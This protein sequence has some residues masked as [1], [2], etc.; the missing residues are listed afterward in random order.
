M[1]K[2]L[3]IKGFGLRDFLITTLITLVVG[4]IGAWAADMNTR[5]AKTE[6]QV[7]EDHTKLEVIIKQGEAL[8]ERQETFDHKLDRLINMHLP[9]VPHAR[10]Q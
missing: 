3:P 1:V 6:S 10:G 7:V 2:L 5:V 4:L 8:V 9:E